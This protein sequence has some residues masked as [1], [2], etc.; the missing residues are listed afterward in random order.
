MELLQYAQ[1]GLPEDIRRCKES[2][3]YQEAI[4]LIDLRLTQPGIPQA[5]K[6]SLLY[7][8]DICRHILEE[9]PYSKEDALALIRRRIPDFEGAL[10]DRYLD[11]RRVRWIFCEGEI[12]IFDRFFDSLC[13]TVPDF[14]RRAK[15][16]LPG[17]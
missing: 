14:A 3:R 1:F 11:E 15:R 16:N 17:V 5:L 9:F 7:Q 13:K 8:R 6:G 12:R 10:L 2:G 4:R